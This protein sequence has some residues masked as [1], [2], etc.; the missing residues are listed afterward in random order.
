[1][2]F[3]ILL[4][5]NAHDRE[6]TGFTS[7]NDYVEAIVH[8]CYES[9]GETNAANSWTQYVTHLIYLHGCKIEVD[10]D[11]LRRKGIEC[12]AV[13]PAGPGPE[14]MV[15]EPNVLERVLNGICK[16]SG[17]KRRVTVQNFPVRLS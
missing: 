16:A 1:M 9:S 15:Y 6:T 13:L 12:C 14:G 2:R 11:D 7:A 17:L 4:L 10:V 5:N 3:K 8:A